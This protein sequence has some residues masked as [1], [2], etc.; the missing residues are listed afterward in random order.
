MGKAPCK[1]DHACKVLLQHNLP[2]RLYWQSQYCTCLYRRYDTVAKLGIAS[3]KQ[4]LQATFPDGLAL[5]TAFVSPSV[6]H[7]LDAAAEDAVTS[8]SWCDMQALLPSVLTQE[9]ASLLLEHCPF[10][11]S[12]G[13]RLC[14]LHFSP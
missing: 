5:E 10:M 13:E 14:A 9:D 2:G 7:Q 1:L 12:A 11:Q 6:V 8:S 3:A 4:H